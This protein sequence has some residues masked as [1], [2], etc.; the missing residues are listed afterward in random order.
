MICST[1]AHSVSPVHQY[2]AYGVSIR[3]DL[4]LPL[5]QA[6]QPALFELQIRSSKEPIL[7]AVRG[8]I[9]LEENLPSLFDIGWLSDG[10]HYV[11]LRGI[12][13][14]LVAGDG[15][16]IICY[17]LPQSNS[18]SFDVYLLAQALSFS[19]VKNGF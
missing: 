15:R 16:S 12:G 19:L 8:A 4:P 10:S 2:C 9:E 6:Q 1:A 11:G 14:I 17:R 18:E 3:S 13:E 5:P 7:P